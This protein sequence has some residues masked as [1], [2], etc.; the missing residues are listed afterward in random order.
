MLSNAMI[1]NSQFYSKHVCDV[2]FIELFY[3]VFQLCLVGGKYT[4]FNSDDRMKIGFIVEMLN[5]EAEMS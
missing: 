4:V 3:S 1:T 2:L 5:D